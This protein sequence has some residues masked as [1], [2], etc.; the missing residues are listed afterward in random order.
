MFALDPI[1]LNLVFLS[2]A[3][4]SVMLVL[5]ALRQPSPVAYIVTG[6]LLGPYV[7]GVF[8]DFEL[9]ERLG[10][11][12]LVLLLFFVGT[13]VSL[14]R[15]A[16]NWRIVLVGTLLQTAL[17]LLVMALLGSVLDWPLARIILFGFVIS[18]SSTAVVLQ[19]L[20][21]R[22]LLNTKLGT[23]VTGILVMQDLLLV[24]MLLI[25]SSLGGDA[26][27]V[28][29]WPYQL[30]G[31][32]VLGTILALVLGR[33]L[34]PSP[35]WLEPFRKEK[36]LQLFAA[37]LVCFGLALAT[38][39][40]GLSLGLGAFAAGILVAHLGGVKWVRRQLHSFRTFFIA[41]FFISIGLLID[42]SYLREN[43]REVLLL[44]FLVL[45][46]NTL[47]NAFVFRAHGESWRYS[48]FAGSL[49]AQIGELS[50]LLAAVGLAQRAITYDGYQ[51][52]V[53]V[54]A[55]TLLVS[56][57]WIRLVG[58]RADKAPSHAA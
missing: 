9:L 15:F 24:P 7:L 4:V 12:G 57:L 50:F 56:P 6:V 35:H 40:L 2:W 33:D 38:G 1:I 55:L 51:T 58:A 25:M 3:V 22:S 34:A 41:L 42:L 48:F 14:S 45:I 17:S 27:E 53:L 20:E 8:H 5:H 44:V 19:F 11:L 46:L 18:L 43:L 39:Y 21:E 13:E 54:I 47:I 49:L 37:L 31:L 23:E 29:R 36:E 30:A 52:V 10:E 26:S 32:V 28:A 16:K